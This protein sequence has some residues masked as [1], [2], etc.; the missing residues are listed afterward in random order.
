MTMHLGRPTWAE[1]DLGAI[2]HNL[3]EL[4]KCLTGSARLMPVIKANA[5]GHGIIE[6]ARVCIN[7]GADFLAVAMLDEALWLRE[8][9]IDRGNI[10]ILGYTPEDEAGKAVDHGFRL[11]VFNYRG[12]EAVSRAASRAGKTGY[13]HLKIDTGMGRLGFFPDDNSLE[14]IADIFRLPGVKVEGIFTHFAAA[15]S[16]DKTYTEWQLKRFR[17]FIA[18]LESRGLH[19]PLK[20]A[21]NSAALMDIPAAHFD[22][23]RAGIS[24]YG[25]EPS[26]E[27]VNRSLN[28]IP[29]MRL[30]SRIVMLK[31]VPPGS[32]ISYGC[33]YVTSRITRVATVPIGYADGYTRL[34]SGKVHAVVRGQ[35]VPGIGRICMDQCMFDV[36]GVD[37]VK[38]GD[39]IV[40]FGR[41]EDG[42]TADEL[43][44]LLGTINYEIVCM[45]GPRVPRIYRHA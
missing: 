32:A 13:I 17:D 28:L 2:A 44:E 26:G 4:K 11:T 3:R 43:A 6:V 37:G 42:V 19:I 10:L 1:I 14:V 41:P 21:A 30:L 7:E 25:L 8:S 5:Y 9:G 16:A 23:V 35:R 40:L 12:A 29:A 27:I 38:E 31:E 20:H 34:L 36:S 18:R 24:I 15:D 39:Q 45:I 22:L 33:T